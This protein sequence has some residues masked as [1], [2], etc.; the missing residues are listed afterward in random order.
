MG[1]QYQPFAYST[2]TISSCFVLD[3]SCQPLLLPP[4]P[5]AHQDLQALVLVDLL[6][7]EG[8]QVVLV[9]VQGVHL[10][11]ILHSLVAI[12]H[13]LV[14]ILSSLVALIKEVLS[15]DKGDLS[16]VKV[17]SSKEVPMQL[18]LNLPWIP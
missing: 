9:L 13:S 7:P 17:V 1:I 6:I 12:L 10:G 2:K 18:L 15:Q 4:W 5:R 14:A 11:A 8:E 3:S 16:L